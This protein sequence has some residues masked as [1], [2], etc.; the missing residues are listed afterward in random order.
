MNIPEGYEVEISAVNKLYTVAPAHL[1]P[2][3]N[4]W[5]LVVPE[6]VPSSPITQIEQ[7]VTVSTEPEWEIITPPPAIHIKQ[8]SD[9]DEYSSHSDDE[10][11][12]PSR[13]HSI[14]STIGSI[15]IKQESE[16]DTSCIFHD[17]EID[18]MKSHPGSTIIGV[19]QERVGFESEMVLD[20]TH[21]MEHV[22]KQE[23]FIS[24]ESMPSVESTQSIGQRI[25]VKEE[26]SEVPNTMRSSAPQKKQVLRT[27]KKGRHVRRRLTYDDVSYIII[28]MTAI[29]MT[30]I[31]L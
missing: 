4:D 18:E 11:K 10:S 19:K 17:N 5:K 26:I 25:Q 3:T 6:D 24:D 31:R 23:E 30:K 21:G 13:S 20:N 27:T 14:P 22:N 16:D 8:E 7:S 29:M 1:V 28:K 9:E 15:C 2:E 12:P